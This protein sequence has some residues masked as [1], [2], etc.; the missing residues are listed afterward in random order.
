MKPFQL[1]IYLL[2]IVT[3]GFTAC[4]GKLSGSTQPRHDPLPGETVTDYE[5]LVDALHAA[6][7]Q[8]EAGE[9]VDQPFF[10]V[11]GRIIKVHEEDIQ[12]FQYP[13]VTVRDEQAALVSSDGNGLGTAKI[14]WIGRPHFYKKGR[15]I[16]LYVGDTDNVL[17]VLGTVLGQP[18]AGK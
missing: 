14:H 9:E 8:V 7:V 3:V 16:V 5:S 2:F 17:K 13:N 6:R 12:V 18:F 10:S 11:E 15:L 1:P 4:G